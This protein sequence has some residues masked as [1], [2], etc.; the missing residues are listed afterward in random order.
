MDKIKQ[1]LREII[2]LLVTHKKALDMDMTGIGRATT[3]FTIRM[4]SADFGKLLGKQSANYKAVRYLLERMALGTSQ[5]AVYELITPDDRTPKTKAPFQP[6]PEFNAKPFRD[7]LTSIVGQVLKYDCQTSQV[8][9]MDD[10][11]STTFEVAI[12]RMYRSRLDDEERKPGLPHNLDTLF[13][14]LGRNN[15]RVINVTVAWK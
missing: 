10:E 7:L 8:Q 6:D 4:H 5:S 15:G 2:G 12:P 11:T 13:Q 9:Q 14:A 1:I 3:K